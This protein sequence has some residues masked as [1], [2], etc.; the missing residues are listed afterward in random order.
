M[1]KINIF[2]V[3]MFVAMVPFTAVPVL[4][5]VASSTNYLIEADS[6]NIGGTEDGTSTNYKLR[7]TIGE[8]GTGIS[9]SANYQI[10]AGYRSMLEAFISISSPGNITLTPSIS[11]ISGGTGTGSADF[12]VITD[13]AAGY[14][15]MVQ[16]STN[17][18]LQVGGDSFADYTPAGANPDYTWSVAATASEFGF[19]PEGTDVTSEYLDDGVSACG[20]GGVLNTTNKCWRGFATTNETVAQS[21]AANAPAGTDTT[22]LL[23]AEV[24]NNKIQPAGSYV[25]TITVT[26]ISN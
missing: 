4:A 13:A 23:Q 21:A 19:S 24:G 26:A 22:L 7:D 10:S 5:Y 6:I 2:I 17:P 16:A 25:A 9:S 20:T 3:F 18:A 8:V 11:G 1:T 15:L 12:T 14:T